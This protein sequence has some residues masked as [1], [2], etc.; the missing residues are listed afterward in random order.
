MWR[1]PAA[2]AAAAVDA[3]SV[4]RSRSL[5]ARCRCGRTPA[6]HVARRRVRGEKNAYKYRLSNELDSVRIAAKART[7]P[8]L[9]GQAYRLR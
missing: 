8:R 7:A 5:D 4:V 2:A 9:A 1:K 6:L 3:R